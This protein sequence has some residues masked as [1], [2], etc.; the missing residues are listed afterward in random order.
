MIKM[1]NG[2]RAFYRHVSFQLI[3]LPHKFLCCMPCSL[4]SWSSHS[5]SM[6]HCYA[7]VHHTY[8]K[9]QQ[10]QGRQCRNS[11]G[12]RNSVTSRGVSPW[13]RQWLTR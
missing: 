4:C 10:K 13:N 2:K 9:V 3:L 6:Q 7:H 11:K 5:C 1:S 8:D 12:T